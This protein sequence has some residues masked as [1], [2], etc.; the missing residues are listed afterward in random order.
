MGRYDAVLLTE[1]E[2]KIRAK[3]KELSRRDRP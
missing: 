3:R 1:L 2:K